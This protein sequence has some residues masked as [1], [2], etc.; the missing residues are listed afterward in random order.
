MKAQIETERNKI[1][2]VGGTIRA[3]LRYADGSAAPVVVGGDSYISIPSTNY[4]EVADGVHDRRVEHKED[5]KFPWEEQM[6]ELLETMDFENLYI[7]F[8]KFDKGSYFRPHYHLTDETITLVEGSYISNKSMYTKGD[9][10]HVP[11]EQIH[12]WE[13]VESGLALLTLKKR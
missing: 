3:T 13:T 11:A 1:K 10:Q 9:T 7:I 5:I 2:N 4:I 12:D 8:V 6:K